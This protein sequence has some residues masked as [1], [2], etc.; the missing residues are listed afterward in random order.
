MR[1]ASIRLVPLG[2]AVAALVMPA[3]AFAAPSVTLRVKAVP[4]PIEPSNAKSRTYPHTGNILGAGAAVEAEY[5]ISGTEY[6]GF[7]LPLKRVTFYLPNGA[8]LH[9]QGFAKC[10]QKVLEEHEVG[11]C[12]KKSI[13][14]PRGEVVG[15]VRF[16]AGEPITE[17]ATVQAFFS[18]SGLSFFTEGRSPVSL[19]ILSTGTFATAPKPFGPKLTAEVPL[20]ATVPGAPF[21]SVMF[22]KVK[23]GAAYKQGKKLV[24]Y[25]TVPSKCP[26]GGFKIK[27][28]LVFGTEEGPAG[29]TVLA[30]ATVPCPKK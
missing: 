25:G 24:S 27:S 7:P 29:E 13:A 17:K 5:K 4:I 30:S 12:P 16:G 1:R 8:K 14:S 2:I 10:S 6:D 3:G 28:E 23:V 22:I 19:E 21:A 18:T 11:K 9:P 20:V 26:K 15:E